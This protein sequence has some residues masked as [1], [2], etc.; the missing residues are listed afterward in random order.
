MNGPLAGMADRLSVSPHTV[1]QHLK[2][3]F[4]KTGVRSRREL[5]EH[6]FFHHYSP[7]FRDNETREAAGLAMRGIPAPGA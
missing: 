4:D 2:S 7:R 3:I 6:A 1:Q 5:V